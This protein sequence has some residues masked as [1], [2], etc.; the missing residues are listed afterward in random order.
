LPPCTHVFTMFVIAGSMPPSLNPNEVRGK[1]ALCGCCGKGNG[2]H[3]QGLWPHSGFI[4]AAP[5]PHLDEN[6]NQYALYPSSSRETWYMWS[7]LLIAS[8]IAL[9]ALIYGAVEWLTYLQ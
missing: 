3:H 9:P 7:D 6:P 2:A 5:A 4:A 8:L 1:K